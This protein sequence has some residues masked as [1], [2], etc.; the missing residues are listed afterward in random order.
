MINV[1]QIVPSNA[2]FDRY[3]DPTTTI[4]CTSIVPSHLCLLFCH[5]IFIFLKALLLL[6]PTSGICLT[7]RYA[8]SFRHTYDVHLPTSAIVPHINY[9]HQ[10]IT[11]ALRIPV[12]CFD[13]VLFSFLSSLNVLDVS[14]MGF[15]YRLALLTNKEHLINSAM[16][17][18]HWTEK[19]CLLPPLLDFRE[20]GLLLKD[21]RVQWSLL[22][23]PPPL[24][25][26][27]SA[28]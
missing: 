24:F 23:L 25:G 19:M 20:P 5:F 7:F 21:K 2:S 12:G 11:G 1:S 14:N 13:C 17:V 4:F 16:G 22:S 10:R 15:T 8:L 27:C 6:A 26:L 28:A 3:D 18:H 9:V